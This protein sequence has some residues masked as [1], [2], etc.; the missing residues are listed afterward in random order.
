[1]SRLAGN[2]GGIWSNVRVAGSSVHVIRL[3]SIRGSSLRELT[4][5]V[6]LQLETGQEDQDEPE[7]AADLVR[8][9]GAADRAAESEL[10]ERYQ[11]RLLYVMR[12]QASRYPDEVED[13]VQSALIIVIEKLRGAAI[14]EPARLGGY[15]YGIANNLRLAHH[16][17]RLRHDGTSNPDVLERVSDGLAEPER[18]VAG[19]ELTRQVRRVI[20]ELGEVRDREILTR[21]YLEQ[22][23]RAEICE[24]LDIP[25]DHFR[26]VLHRARNRLKSLL[27]ADEYKSDKTLDD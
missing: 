17:D 13:L 12:R 21:L 26:R 1:M 10:F 11:P 23:E 3:V 18:L 4:R 25:P 22:Q 2:R 16:R 20:A 15:I 5:R 19:E 24:A 7:V 9:I 8:R 14:A 6:E 27:R